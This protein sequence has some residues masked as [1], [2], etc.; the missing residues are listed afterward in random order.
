MAEDVEVNIHKEKHNHSHHVTTDHPPSLAEYEAHPGIKWTPHWDAVGAGLSAD[1][2][3]KR[4]K[5]YGPNCL[6]EKHVNPIIKYLKNYWGPMPIMIWAA[7]FLILAKS[8]VAKTTGEGST[9]WPDFIMCCVLQFV[10]GNVKWYN[11][12]NAENAIKALKDKMAPQAIV[13]RDGEWMTI[14]AKLLVPGDVV[15]VR[16]G[17]I[18]AADGRLGCGE[19]LQLDQAALTGESLPRNKKKRDILYAGTVVKRGD[20]E[21]VVVSTGRFTEMGRAANMV[22]SV[23]TKSRY[24]FILFWVAMYLLTLSLTL[25]TIQ[26]VK[27]SWID[28]RPDEIKPCNVLASLSVVVL[29]LV[30]ALPVAMHVV[31][32]VIMAMGAFRLS[33]HKAVV[34]E[35][36]ATEE[37]SGMTVDEIFTKT[38]KFDVEMVQ[39]FKKK[40]F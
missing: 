13:R 19:N 34:S 23:K 38:K 24:D 2:A 11:G 15:Q 16:I 20:G 31:C 28:C 40:C 12:R 14:Q 27:M 3:D 6:P 10:N 5:E 33:E 39:I 18:C 21:Y 36:T 30:G 35:L 1:E 7:I 17:D 37:L 29:I 26:F 4:L 25:M 8:L 22:A 32:M 9:S